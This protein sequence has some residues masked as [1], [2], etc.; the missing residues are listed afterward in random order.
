MKNENSQKTHIFLSQLTKDTIKKDLTSD[1]KIYSGFKPQY[2]NFDKAASRDLSAVL[3]SPRFHIFK[4]ISLATDM[5]MNK[6]FRQI[7]NDSIDLPFLERSSSKYQIY[8]KMLKCPSKSS[9]P[10][11]NTS[12]YFS[13]TKPRKLHKKHFNKS[14]IQELLNECRKL[15][16]NEER[17]KNYRIPAR[18][19][20]D[21]ITG[22][23][24]VKNVK[25]LGMQ[26]SS[27]MHKEM[28][29]QVKKAKEMTPD[30][31]AREIE[32]EVKQSKNKNLINKG[33]KILAFDILEQNFKTAKKNPDDINELI[34][35][36]ERYKIKKENGILKLRENLS[37][38][39]DNQMNRCFREMD[40][41]D[42][43]VFLLENI[44]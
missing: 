12:T 15:T 31:I 6:T 25:L 7:S 9:N 24:L 41:L 33:N 16:D 43:N 32:N 22:K 10:S 17:M 27:E 3:S 42:G 34:N 39:F 35:L 4:K 11:P 23:Y 21:K 44:T 20:V 13:P 19:L 36:G 40:L 5:K 8:K 26:I 38:K 29:R 14:E 18:D 2:K 30:D 28:E 1:L 37:L